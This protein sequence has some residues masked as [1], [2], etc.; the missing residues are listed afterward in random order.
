MGNTYNIQYPARFY[1]GLDGGKNTRVAKQWLL[2][3]ESPDCQNVVFG[4]GSV[5]TRQGTNILNTATVGTF[6]CDGLYTRHDN[7]GSEQMLAWFNGTLHKLAT[8]TFIAEASSTCHFTAGTR[9]YAAEYENNMFFGNGAGIPMRYNGTEFV[10]HGVYPPTSTASVGAN[11]ANSTVLSGTYQWA[12]TY[13]NSALVESDLSPV[14]S[15]FTASGS[16]GAYLTSIPVAP[17]SFGVNKRYIYRTE[18]SGVAYYRAG[19]LSNN[20]ATVYAEVTTD[21]ALGVAAPT[22]QGVPPNYSAVLTHQSR[23]FFID[24]TSTFVWYTESGNPY[25]VKAT[26]F[27]RIGDET[28]DVPLALGIWD[29]YLVEFCKSMTYMTYM[30]SADDSD[31]LDFK[32]RSPFGSKSPLGVL[33]AMNQTI[34]PAVSNGKFVGF[35]ALTA[36]GLDPQAT[37]T[38]TG[39]IGS[40]LMTEPIKSDMELFNPTYL[41]NV[42]SI[43]HEQRAYIAYTVTGQAK[44]TKM[45]LMDF[46]DEHLNKKQTITWVPWTG[47]NIS[48]FCIYGGNL[49][50][51]TSDSVGYVYK[52]NN[53]TYV[54]GSTA[55]DSYIWT[56]EFAGLPGHES[57]HKDFRFLNLL[58]DLGGSWLNG[59]TTRVDSDMGDGVTETI[60]CD[61]GTILW[62]AFS[63]GL[64][65]WEAGRTERDLKKPLG[66]FRGKRI[67]FKFS[68][69]NIKNTKFKV[70]GLSLTYNLK[71]RR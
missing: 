12:V 42:T 66:Q 48:Q 9:V 36:S 61:P 67:Q 63:W 59:I 20:T 38:E 64:A 58:Y 14:T 69:L 32:L 25:V 1:T 6:P 50:Y 56:K 45:Y 35:A 21:A 3:N 41:G 17:K 30:P 16:T 24:P 28:G 31:W 4:Y 33:N 26:N 44:N 65:N 46:S 53:G 10:R 15:T 22:D 8:T 19:V 11:S 39:A 13:V 40:Q 27:R 29:N 54:D 47:L 18:N 23:L 71:G 34:F 57:W 5:E 62:G 55:I 60:D 68:N 37:I 7:T 70:V 49:Y 51:G 2:D 52:M 43:V